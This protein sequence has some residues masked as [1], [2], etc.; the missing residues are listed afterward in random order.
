MFDE[1]LDVLNVYMD[2]D[3]YEKYTICNIYYDTE[4]PEILTDRGTYI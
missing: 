3:D 2:K 1:L 4:N